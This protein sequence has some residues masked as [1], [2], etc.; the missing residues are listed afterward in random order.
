[1]MIAVDAMLSAL[2]QIWKIF[3]F[4]EPDTEQKMYLEVE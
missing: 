4:F 2:H 3:R 1:M